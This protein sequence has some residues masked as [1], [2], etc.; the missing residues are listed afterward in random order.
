MNRM[1]RTRRGEG[2]KGEGEEEEDFSI[3]I[4]SC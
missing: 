3:L 1:D 4:V 2:E